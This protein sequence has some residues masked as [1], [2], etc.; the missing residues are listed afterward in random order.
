MARVQ[1]VRSSRSRTRSRLAGALG[2]PTSALRAVRA[3]YARREEPYAG[4]DMDTARRL[5]GVVWLLSAAILVGLLPFHPPTETIGDAGWVVA[6]AV[7][8]LGLLGQRAAQRTERTHYELLLKSYTAV[9]AIAVVQWLSGGFGAPYHELFLFWAVSTAA[10]HPPR[11]ATMFLAVLGAAAA[12]P[13]LYE[14]WDSARAGD[15]AL[16]LVLYF[17]LGLLAVVLVSNM[18]AQRLSLRGREEAAKRQARVDTLTGLGNRRALEEMLESEV[19][20]AAR[21]GRPLCLVTADIDDFKR[22]NDEHGHLEGDR[23]LREVAEALRRAVRR[24][25]ACFRWGGDEFAILLPETRAAGAVRVC[26]RLEAAVPVPIKWGVAEGGPEMDPAE[27]LSA[28]DQALIAAK[29]SVR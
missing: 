9:A 1:A 2:F 13:L 5:G 19:A 20:R 12:L 24:P 23:V 7:L 27:L 4:A 16:D 25:D 29:G 11:P 10:V 18:R 26:R 21:T 6:G 8:V 17:A 28:S 15:I 22:F 3:F 14:G